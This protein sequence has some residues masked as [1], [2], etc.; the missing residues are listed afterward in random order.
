MD[1]KTLDLTTQSGV[2]SFMQSAKSE[3]DWNSR[4]DQVKSAN[5]GNYPAFWFLSIVLS[6]IASEAQ[7]RWQ[8]SN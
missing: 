3:S 4:C 7:S 2:K 8:R 1:T 5:G 6:G